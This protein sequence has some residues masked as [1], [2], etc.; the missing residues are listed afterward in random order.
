MSEQAG[1]Y[2]Q[3]FTAEEMAAGVWKSGHQPDPLFAA[4]I[5]PHFETIRSHADYSPDG[6]V[7]VANDLVVYAKDL[8]DG[9]D[10]ELAKYT[11]SLAEELKASPLHPSSED[12]A[13]DLAI[14]LSDLELYKAHHTRMLELGILRNNP[15]IAREYLAQ[16][17][18]QK[19]DGLMLRNVGHYLQFYELDGPELDM[20]YVKTAILVWGYE[21][22]MTLPGVL[23]TLIEETILREPGSNRPIKIVTPLQVVRSGDNGDF[24]M[25]IQGNSWSGDAWN[26]FTFQD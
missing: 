20:A 17:L 8:R 19:P 9:D 4:E 11:A 16:I 3:A 13:V 12:E 7:G 15:D 10:T 6:I 5:N 21:G 26:G 2:P 14:K 18:T 23:S 22:S 1:G 24:N 25:L